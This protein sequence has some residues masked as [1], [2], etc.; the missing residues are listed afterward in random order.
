MKQFEYFL[1]QHSKFI[2]LL[3]AIIMTSI[4]LSFFELMLIIS[5][6]NIS[7]VVAGAELSETLV[8]MSKSI[9]I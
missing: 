9:E 7:E 3:L 1:L 4:A 2:F 5:F 6:A 8:N